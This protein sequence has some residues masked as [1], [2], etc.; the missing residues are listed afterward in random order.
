MVQQ[1]LRLVE[2][3]LARLEQG[4]VAVP[5]PRV[6]VAALRQLAGRPEPETCPERS[7]RK[8]LEKPWPWLFQVEHY[9]LGAWQE[10]DNGSVRCIYCGSDPVAIKSKKPRLK[11]YLDAQ[12]QRQTV[13]V[14]RYYCKNPDCCY[15]TFTNLPPGLM[16]HSVWTLDARLK[17]LEL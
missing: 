1:L 14:Y 13:E 2:E 4:Q 10:V 17:A 7:R 9:L 16:V 3:L 8:R 6:E 5:E 12:G 15:Q 11:A